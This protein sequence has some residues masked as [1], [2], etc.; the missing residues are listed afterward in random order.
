MTKKEME[1]ALMSM[2][3]NQKDMEEYGDEYRADTDELLVFKGVENV[4]SFDEYLASTDN[5]IIVDL[6]NGKQLRLT[7][8]VC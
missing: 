3:W 5:G 7:I 6:Q 4:R 2:F 1:K 8:Q